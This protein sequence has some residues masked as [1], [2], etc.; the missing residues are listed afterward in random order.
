MQRR[1]GR[2]RLRT[3]RM[4]KSGPMPPHFQRS[5]T[6]VDIT[7]SSSHAYGQALTAAD[8]AALREKDITPSGRDIFIRPADKFPTLSSP[9]SSMQHMNA[10]NYPALVLNPLATPQ[11]IITRRYRLKE[12]ELEN[13]KLVPENPKS[14]TKVSFATGHR[15][16][17]ILPIEPLIK[18]KDTVIAQD[19]ESIRHFLR[20]FMSAMELKVSQ[21]EPIS[22][23]DIFALLF[24]ALCVRKLDPH[25]VHFDYHKNHILAMRL[26][27]DKT[28]VTFT[29][30]QPLD[31]QTVDVKIA[32]ENEG[33]N[34]VSITLDHLEY[35]FDPNKFLFLNMPLQFPPATASPSKSILKKKKRRR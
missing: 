9:P 31:R 33:P 7:A 4:A 5:Q 14:P 6:T 21:N 25:T 3:E 28:S 27:E 22:F 20:I 24:V 34:P 11:N 8:V 1:L 35:P 16:I 29:S 30:I 19:I 12:L 18:L 32:S 26:S 2:P 17:D 15:E 23:A 13:S 10:K